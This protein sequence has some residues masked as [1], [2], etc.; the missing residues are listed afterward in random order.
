MSDIKFSASL[1]AMVDKANKDD[2]QLL[3]L[4]DNLLAYDMPVDPAFDNHKRN[5]NGKIKE[6]GSHRRA[7]EAVFPSQ[8]EE[9]NAI[10]H[11]F[12]V[13]RAN[14]NNCPS[15]PYHGH[16]APTTREPAI[17]NNYYNNNNNS[18]SS[19]SSFLLSEKFKEDITQW[20]MGDV[21][22]ES[23]EEFFARLGAAAACSELSAAKKDEADGWEQVT[24]ADVARELDEDYMYPGLDVQWLMMMRGEWAAV[25]G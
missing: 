19:S 20:R 16:N 3:L 23:D 22:H 4:G 6:P 18:S 7:H 5:P 10:K 8:S 11:H 25:C 12:N 21:Q 2:G 9:N 13:T 24:R 14:L 17:V 1:P 15:C